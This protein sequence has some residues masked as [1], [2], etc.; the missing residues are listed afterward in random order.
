MCSVGVELGITH[1]KKDIEMRKLTQAEVISA[2]KSVFPEYDYSRFEYRGSNVRSIVI[3]PKH[4]EF[5]A[6]YDRVKLGHGCPSCGVDRR[7]SKK[8]LTNEEA[9]RRM[10]EIRPEYDYSLFE[11]NGAAVKGVV[12]CEKHGKFHASYQSIVEDHGCPK[13][14]AEAN[15]L[16]NLKPAHEAI[17]EMQGFRPEYDM[18]KFEYVSCHTKSI[19]VCPKH[20]EFL[21]N[22][23]ALKRGRG[24][25]K[26]G[27]ERRTAARTLTQEAAVALM[28]E[29]QPEYD[30]SMFEYVL[31][32]ALGVVVC[33]KHGPFDASY[34]SIVNGIRCRHCAFEANAEKAR[35]PFEEFVERAVAIHGDLYTYDKN[36]YTEISGTVTAEC[37]THGRFKVRCGELING[38][39]CPDCKDSCFNHKKRAFLYIGKLTVGEKEYV[40]YG[41]TGSIVRRSAEHAIRAKNAGATYEVLHTFRFRRG[42]YC[43]QVENEIIATFDCVDTGVRGFRKEAAG[44]DSYKDIVALATARHSELKSKSDI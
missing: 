16:R 13:C 14:K 12:I 21:V 15:R 24:C 41:I 5:P 32:S 33:P 31:S 1:K 4:G 39:G 38:Q 19:A 22:Y 36:T 20:G 34:I 6:R 7:A 35:I 29:A 42:L 26:C 37:K 27:I 17:A 10:K 9:V 44:W 18:S 40:G 23:N 2:M 30:Y 28:Q 11:Y 43:R 8:K 25:P 3:C